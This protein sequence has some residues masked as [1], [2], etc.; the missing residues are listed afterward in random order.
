MEDELIEILSSN[1]LSVTKVFRIPYKKADGSE[2]VH[3]ILIA[4]KIANP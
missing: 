3:L 4:I 2:Q 1:D